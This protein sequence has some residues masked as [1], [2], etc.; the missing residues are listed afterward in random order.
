[1]D[2][3]SLKEETWELFSTKKGRKTKLKYKYEAPGPQYNYVHLENN[4]L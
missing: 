1:M 3:C 4:T 2:F